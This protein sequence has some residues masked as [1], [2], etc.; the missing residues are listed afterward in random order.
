MPHEDG[1]AWDMSQAPEYRKTATVR[2]EQMDRPFVVQTNEGT[3]T[4]EIGDYL[5][6]GPAGD[7]WPV[8]RHI[9]EATYTPKGA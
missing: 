2:A 4:G 3:M 5:C 9:F 1:N 8:K 6:V 7:R